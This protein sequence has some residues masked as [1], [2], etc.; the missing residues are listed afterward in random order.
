LVDSLVDFDL[1]FQFLVGE[2]FIV[3]E[4]ECLLGVI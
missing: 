3:N 2:V 4:V 1:S